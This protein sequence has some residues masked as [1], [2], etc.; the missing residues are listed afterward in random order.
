MSKYRETM[1]NKYGS[2]E[3][4]KEHLAAIGSKGGKVKKAKGFA[5][6]TA[7]QRSEW[8]RKGGKISRRQK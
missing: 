6:A 4:W 3:K 1:I 2:L 8:G 5:V 7:E